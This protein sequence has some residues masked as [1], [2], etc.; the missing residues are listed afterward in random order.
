MPHIG[1]RPEAS[2][3]VLCSLIFRNISFS[4]RLVGIH[5]F[6]LRSGSGGS[7]DGCGHSVSRVLPSHG[8]AVS[9]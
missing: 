2:L 4:G 7:R 9:I 6:G 8:A 3:A 5:M 1:D